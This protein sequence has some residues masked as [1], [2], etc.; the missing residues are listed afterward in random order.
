M[1]EQTGH[2]MA[3]TLFVMAQEVSTAVHSLWWF[4][5]NLRSCYSVCCPE[6]SPR[7]VISSSYCPQTV[8]WL[9]EFPTILRLLREVA[10]VMGMMAMSST[11]LCLPTVVLPSSPLWHVCASPKHLSLMKLLTSNLIW[12]EWLAD[13]SDIQGGALSAEH[14]SLRKMWRGFICLTCFSHF[15]IVFISYSLFNGTVS[16]SNCSVKTQSRGSHFLS[17]HQCSFIPVV[18]FFCIIV[19]LQALHGVRHVW[20]SNVGDQMKKKCFDFDSNI[21]TVIICNQLSLP[22][23]ALHLLRPIIDITKQKLS[24]SSEVITNFRFL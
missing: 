20:V 23:P 19:S 4:L 1:V 3:E 22:F 7:W 6:Q 8:S 10:Q 11:S 5:S 12:T 24:V 18:W 9:W 13:R 21:D 17:S 14:D 2:T 15:G 16:S